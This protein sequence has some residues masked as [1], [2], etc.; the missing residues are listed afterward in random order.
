MPNFQ[1]RE[2]QF[3]LDAITEIVAAAKK[4]LRR[5]QPGAVLLDAPTG[6]GKTVTTANAIARLV[7][8]YPEPLAFIWIAPNTLQEQSLRRLQDLYVDNKSLSCLDAAGLRGAEL[9]DRSILFLNWASVNKSSNVL[10]KDKEGEE[11]GS[12]T[13][14]TLQELLDATRSAGRKIVLIVDE[15]HRDINGVQAQLVVQNIIAPDLTLEISATPVLKD[16][17]DRVTVNRDDVVAAG[18]IRKQFNI[19]PGV[20]GS[21]TLEDGKVVIQEAGSAELL[22]DVAMSHRRNLAE[23]FAAQGS[24]VNPLVLV[25]LPDKGDVPSDIR[26]RIEDHLHR[27]HGV[28]VAN[29]KAAIWLSGEHVNKDGIEAADSPV[30]LLFFKQA[31]ALGWDCPRAHILVS[32][33][34]MKSPTFTAQVL[35]RILRQPEHRHYDDAL[36]DSAYVFTNYPEFTLEKQFEKVMATRLVTAERRV[37]FPLPCWREVNADQRMHL[38]ESAYRMILSYANAFSAGVRHRGPVTGAMVSD[39]ALKNIDVDEEDLRVT[40]KGDVEYELNEEQLE[41]LLSWRVRKLT[42]GLA[43]QVDGRKHVRRALLE[44]A[45]QQLPEGTDKELRE[46]VLHPTNESAIERMVQT[47]MAQLK[48]EFEG[49]QRSF[50]E[51]ATWTPRDN[52]VLPWS[53]SLQGFNKCI[54]SPVLAGE[55]NG[56]ETRFAR[57]LDDH[58]AVTAWLKN[59]DKG[60]EHFAIPYKQQGKTHLFFPDFLAVLSDGR[61]GIWDTKGHGID[62]SANYADAPLKAEALVAYREERAEAGVPVEGGLVVEDEHGRWMLHD[63]EGY[64]WSSELQGWRPLADAL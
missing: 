30:E 25:Q 38:T 15:S 56:T 26:E 18:V 64:R 57:F 31:I 4:L 37:E 23:A 52:K 8:T 55:L 47:A 42:K 45:R 28:S 27:V 44:L 6:A 7:E 22:L 50:E 41:E 51:A 60:S 54:Y 49:K 53:K 1:L 33:R 11:Q 34:E 21:L 17:D 58:P 10:R 19:N 59:G 24:K 3:Q 32:L 20:K 14:R 36:L 40:F 13:G 61:I 29:G 9:E 5:N 63:T 12:E 39:L 35:G 43:A 46:V 62:G 48:A 16:Y 2:Y